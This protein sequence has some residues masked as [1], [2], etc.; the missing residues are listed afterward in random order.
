MI[1]NLVIFQLLE[2]KNSSLL[3]R[4]FRGKNHSLKLFLR[5]RN[6]TKKWANLQTSI[7]E[8]IDQSTNFVKLPIANC[9]FCISLSFII[10][11]FFGERKIWGNDGIFSRKS[12]PLFCKVGLSFVSTYFDVQSANVKLDVHIR[13]Y[14][15]FRE[16][17][18]RKS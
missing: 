3:A 15:I 14:D 10:L 18:Y 16:I 11:I 4:I 6:L 1:I 7:I 9:L 13:K 12:G 8:Y 17:N 5:Q 2:I